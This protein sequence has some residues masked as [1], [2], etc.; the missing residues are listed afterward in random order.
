MRG[1]TIYLDEALE[2]RERQQRRRSRKLLG[3]AIA[4]ALL[5]VG[6][7]MREPQAPEPKVVVVPGPVERI[8]ID[9]PVL[10]P[11]LTRF[12]TVTPAV[13]PAG[14]PAVPHSGGRAPGAVDADVP[15]LS[16]GRHWSDLAAPGEPVPH[17]CVTPKTIRFH[18]ATKSDRVTVSNPGTVAIGITQVA[19][20]SGRSATGF[21]VDASDCAGRTLQAGERCTI[22][23]TLREASGETMHLLIANDVSDQA[24][25]IKVES[26][27]AGRTASPASPATLAAAR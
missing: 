21:V 3:G 20:V 14:T 15:L 12:V 6:A 18:G 13:T 7:A 11:R 17:L 26:P 8:Y 23:V 24:D 9:R 5:G 25:T 2:E 19:A 1:V 4:I 16:L 10:L 22:V 27:T